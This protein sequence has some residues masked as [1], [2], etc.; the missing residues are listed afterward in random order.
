MVEYGVDPLCFLVW[1]HFHHQLIHANGV[2]GQK[3]AQHRSPVVELGLGRICDRLEKGR[4]LVVW[5]KDTRTEARR[6]A[7]F[8]AAFACYVKGVSWQTVRIVS[9]ALLPGL[10]KAARMRSITARGAA[11]S[12]P[13]PAT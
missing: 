10:N 6:R 7:L 12:D 3:L 9:T 1:I 2:L 13:M 11:P 5:I 4:C 8:D